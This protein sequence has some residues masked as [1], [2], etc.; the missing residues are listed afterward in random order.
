MRHYILEDKASGTSNWL[1]RNPAVLMANS[2]ILF[3]EHMHRELPNMDI[4]YCRTVCSKGDTISSNTCPSIIWCYKQFALCSTLVNFQRL[5]II[6]VNM[7]R[8]KCGTFSSF[9]WFSPDI[10]HHQHLE[11]PKRG[12]CSLGQKC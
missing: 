8:K 1:H 7:D 10:Y 9:H 11:E 6:A 12:G 3:S 5:K 4:E 2:P